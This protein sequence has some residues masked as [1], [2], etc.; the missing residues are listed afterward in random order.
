MPT[1]EGLEA[2]LHTLDILLIVFGTLVAIGVTGESIVGFLHWRR[3]GQLSAIQNS[4]IARL[5]QETAEANLALAKLRTPRTLTPEQRER[6][7]RAMSAYAG[8]AFAI[9]SAPDPEARDLAMVINEALL[10]ARWQGSR[11]VGAIRA[12]AI[13]LATGRGVEI[14]WA[15]SSSQRTKDIGNALA[16]VLEEQGIATIAGFDPDNRLFL[17][18]LS[19]AVGTKPQ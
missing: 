9:S 6:I 1:R 8:Q 14:D 3:G 19:I 4:E 15:R 18:A 13:A 17:G 2:S 5:Q 12:G 10:S 16:S 7:V 11:P